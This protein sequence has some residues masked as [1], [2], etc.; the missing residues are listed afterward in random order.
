M[1]KIINDATGQIWIAYNT[2]TLTC[3]LL[4]DQIE[5]VWDPDPVVPQDIIEMFWKVKEQGGF[6]PVGTILD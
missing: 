1:W 6:Y 3:H 2:E 5:D 4:Q